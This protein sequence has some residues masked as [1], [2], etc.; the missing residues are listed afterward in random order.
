M[1]GGAVPHDRFLHVLSRFRA[2]HLRYPPR[3]KLSL[4]LRNAPL[5]SK[6]GLSGPPHPN[7]EK[8]D[9]R[10]G[11]PSTKAPGVLE[12]QK[13]LHLLQCLVQRQ[14]KGTATWPRAGEAQLVLQPAIDHLQ[15]GPAQYLL[16][17]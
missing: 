7:V 14:L 10:M 8:R 12:F 16:A 17:P 15:V 5:K 13:L 3:H 4:R 1:G 9:V 6:D 2:T 11:H